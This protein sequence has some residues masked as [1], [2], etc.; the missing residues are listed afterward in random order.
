MHNLTNFMSH[1]AR[2]VVY[3][4]VLLCM[5]NML[6]AVIV[7]VKYVVGCYDACQI[8]CGMYVKL[9]Y[10]LMHVNLR[11]D[12]QKCAKYRFNNYVLAAVC[13]HAYFY[14]Y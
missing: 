8:C 10:V 4:G 3:C 1:S 7:Y 2:Q 12:L 11:Q 5:L 14:F 13:L 9:C 6:F